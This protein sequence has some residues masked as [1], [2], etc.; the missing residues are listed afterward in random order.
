MNKIMITFWWDYP[1]AHY[2]PLFAALRETGVDVR[3]YYFSK[4]PTW[5]KGMGWCAESELPVGEKYVDNDQDIN[6]LVLDE[7]NRIHILPVPT[8]EG[9]RRKLLRAFVYEKVRWF[10]WSEC[11]RPSLLARVILFFK[12]QRVRRSAVGAFGIGETARSQFARYG[13]DPVRVGLLPYSISPLSTSIAPDEKIVRFIRNRK[14][15]VFVGA[16][17]PRKG[18]DV[19]LKAF[20]SVIQRNADLSTDW[21]L[22]IAGPDRKGGRYAHLAERLKIESRVMWYGVVSQSN[23]ARVVSAADVFILP[24]RHDGWGAVLNEAASLGKGLISTEQTGAAHHL[25]NHGINGYRVRGGCVNSL[26]M[27]ME[28]YIRSPILTEIHG[29]ESR[30][31]FQAYSPAANADRLLSQLK[32]FL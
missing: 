4:L 7:R 31:L 17:C 5:R 16:L 3:V 12:I 2:S 29:K 18:V 27:A 32:S 25:I 11:S 13:L 24:S 28:F 21:V 6:Q 26:R 10:H 20:A 22:I 1:G 15:F 30:T 19:L 14:A 8:K 23:V 9:I